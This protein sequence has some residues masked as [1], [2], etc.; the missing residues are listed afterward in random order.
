MLT[1]ISRSDS[2][3]DGHVPLLRALH[4]RPRHQLPLPRGD[5]GGAPDQGRHQPLQ[6]EDPRRWAGHR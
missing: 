2:D 6:G 4:V 3:G 1:L 5:P